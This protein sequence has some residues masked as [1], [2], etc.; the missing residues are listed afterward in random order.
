MF[1]I[2]KTIVSEEIIEKDFMCNLSACKGACCIDGEAGAPLSKEE[3]EILKDIYPK[4]KPFLREKGIKAIES[5]GVILKRNL[6]N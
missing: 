6:L 1:Q 4:V 3:T 2:G 5:Q